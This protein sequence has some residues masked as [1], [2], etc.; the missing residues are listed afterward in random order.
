MSRLEPSSPVQENAMVLP[1]GEKAGVDSLVGDERNGRTL[2][3]AGGRGAE[4]A[5]CPDSES[6]FRRC[7]SA[8]RSAAVW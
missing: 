5:C 3:S 8:R 2:I 6:R 7:R 1:S 4:A